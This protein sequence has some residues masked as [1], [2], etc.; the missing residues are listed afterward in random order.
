MLLPSR[1]EEF[2]K[3][4]GGLQNSGLKFMTESSLSRIAPWTRARKYVSLDQANY[5]LQINIKEVK[6][7]YT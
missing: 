5:H 3:F 6:E 2:H 7:K 1:K 4:E